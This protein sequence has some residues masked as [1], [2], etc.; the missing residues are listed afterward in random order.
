MTSNAIKNLTPLP[1]GMTIKRGPAPVYN[2]E[3]HNANKRWTGK[4]PHS[5]AKSNRETPQ[6]RAAAKANAMRGQRIWRIA[7]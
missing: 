5:P 4:V 6:H 1:A 2:Y 7:K 3:E